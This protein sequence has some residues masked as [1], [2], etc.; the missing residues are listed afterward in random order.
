MPTTGP[1]TTFVLTAGLVPTLTVAVL[2]VAPAVT[3]AWLTRT[4]RVTVPLASASWA[5]SDQVTVLPS[6]ESAASSEALTKSRPAGRA[7]VTVTSATAPVRFAQ[8]MV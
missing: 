3:A 6:A 5:P 7:S 2:S 1:G 8:P 4:V